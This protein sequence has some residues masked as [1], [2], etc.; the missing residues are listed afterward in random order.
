MCIICVVLYNIVTCRYRAHLTFTHV[1]H[2]NMYNMMT[3]TTYH[4]R[5]HASYYKILFDLP[6]MCANDIRIKNVILTIFK[7]HHCTY[8]SDVRRGEEAVAPGGTFGGAVLSVRAVDAISESQISKHFRGHA[9]DSPRLRVRIPP[10]GGRHF[11]I[12]PPS[13]TSARYATDL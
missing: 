2:S 13:V 4:S 10:G 8:S 3:C 6:I 1:Q 11:K 7:C 5:L 12:S 9:P